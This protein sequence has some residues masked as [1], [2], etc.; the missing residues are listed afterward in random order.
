ML[1]GDGLSAAFPLIERGWRFVQPLDLRS[2]VELAEAF[3]L[4]TDDPELPVSPMWVFGRR[5]DAALEKP[6]DT[7]RR[8]NHLRLG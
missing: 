2:A 5:E 6:R 3:L 1:V 7:I 8:R 4:D